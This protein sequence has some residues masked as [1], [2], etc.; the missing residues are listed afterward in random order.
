MRCIL[1]LVDTERKRGGRK[2]EGKSTGHGEAGEDR[3]R[4]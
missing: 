2:R 1:E 4:Q 3:E